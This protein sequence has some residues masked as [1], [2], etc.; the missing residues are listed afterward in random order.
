[1]NDVGL[2]KKALE[3]KGFFRWSKKEPAVS[4]SSFHNVVNHRNLH[5]QK[6][7]PLTETAGPFMAYSE[8]AKRIIEILSSH[9]FKGSQIGFS[10]PKHPCR[11]NRENA[12][13]DYPKT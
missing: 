6:R 10:I 11:G 12:K 9:T 5:F 3:R 2:I 8:S 4:K 13:N 1:M 7:E